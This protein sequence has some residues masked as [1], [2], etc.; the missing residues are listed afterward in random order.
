M[1][2]KFIEYFTAKNKTP[3]HEKIAKKELLK[4]EFPCSQLVQLNKFVQASIEGYDPFSYKERAI[5]LFKTPPKL[6]SDKNTFD[7][8][9]IDSTDTRVIILTGDNFGQ[10]FNYTIE[11]NEILIDTGDGNPFRVTSEEFIH[12]S[13]FALFYNDVI[14][15][16]K[17]FNTIKDKNFK[18]YLSAQNLTLQ[19]SSKTKNFNADELFK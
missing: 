3:D 17:I 13:G 15:A 6:S 1:S 4:K 11:N 7:T 19:T 18:S 12:K 10:T 8:K 14:S 5:F 16:K 9:D 2:L